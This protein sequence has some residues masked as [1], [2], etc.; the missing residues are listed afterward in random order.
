ML[1]SPRWYD[2]GW[3]GQRKPYLLFFCSPNKGNLSNL[4]FCAR[5]QWQLSSYLLS[6]PTGKQ[7]GRQSVRENI[8][9]G[10]IFWI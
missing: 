7:V 8:I 3:V 6:L 10:P 1:I 4:V 5:Q 9:V 2:A